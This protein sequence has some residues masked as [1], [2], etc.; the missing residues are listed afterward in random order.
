MGTFDKGFCFAENIYSSS[1]LKF[2]RFH[3]QD[4]LEV[5][6]FR[7]DAAGRIWIGSQNG[8]IYIILRIKA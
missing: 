3:F 7:E 8:F 1:D 5:Q 6:D 4:N 2:T